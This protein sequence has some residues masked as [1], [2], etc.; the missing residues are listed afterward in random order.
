MKS[1]KKNYLILISCLLIFSNLVIICKESKNH[2][3][4]TNN[5]SYVLKK[6][7]SY[8]WKWSE[9]EVVSSES[10]LSSYYPRVATDKGGNIHV[11]WE[12][13]S[14]YLG[15]GLDKDI[16]YKR[17]NASIGVWTNT[18][19][20]SSPSHGDSRYPDIDVDNLGNVH[21]VWYNSSGVDEVYYRRWNNN[22]NT[23]T[24]ILEITDGCSY[25]DNYP[26]VAT[27]GN[28]NAHFVWVCSNNTVLHYRMWNRTE[29]SWSTIE[30]VT[31]SG[32]P[33]YPDIATDQYGNT[34]FLWSD[35]LDAYY[36]YRNITDKTYLG[37]FPLGQNV[38]TCHSVA[39]D[40]LGHVHLAW[41]DGNVSHTGFIMPNFLQIGA[42]NVTTRDGYNR[43]SIATDSSNNLHL[44]YYNEQED[45]IYY[46][47]RDP[48][49][50]SAPTWS[51][52]ELVSISTPAGFSDIAVNGSN[53]IIIVWHELTSTYVDIVCRR[54]EYVRVIE[55]VI[56]DD[57]GDD[58]SDGDSNENILG[59]V[60]LGVSSIGIISIISV[61]LIKR[62]R[63]L[64]NK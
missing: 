4:E 21:I 33:N 31:A 40:S 39:T 50:D 1:R 9:I 23:W 51:K 27:D 24:S 2:Y 10:V 20:V 42:G 15:C 36:N 7:S 28:G 48:I 32:V 45:R 47:S 62:R 30:T 26:A 11:V 44:T 38:G 35:L 14:N 3:I 12:D 37:N 22:T 6:A 46:K 25:D 16:F 52:Y 49:I 61:I 43:P 60:I 57:N 58:D 5:Q 63:S 55:A 34:H 17:W 59:F 41:N 19:V 8:T 53:M 54:K 13:N 29:D 18:E 64:N 56:M